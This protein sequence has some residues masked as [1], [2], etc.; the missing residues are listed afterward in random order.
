[1]NFRKEVHKK[2]EREDN[3]K[4]LQGQRKSKSMTKEKMQYRDA[5]IHSLKKK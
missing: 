4:P 5:Y 2:K 1:M 3:E